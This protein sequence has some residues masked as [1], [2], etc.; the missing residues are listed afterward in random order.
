MATTP[1][2][3]RHYGQAYKL[4]TV[5]TSLDQGGNVY[6]KCKMFC[7]VLKPSQKCMY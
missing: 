6:V 3:Y 5:H 7:Y 4:N 2:G 1:R